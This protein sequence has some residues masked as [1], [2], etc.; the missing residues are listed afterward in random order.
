MPIPQNQTYPNPQQLR[1]ILATATRADRPDRRD[2]TA[3]FDRIRETNP[4]VRGHILTRQTAVS[5]FGWAISPDDTANPGAVAQ[6]QEAETRLSQA[7]QTILDTHHIAPLYGCAAYAVE[8]AVSET[9]Q[10][11]NIRTLPRN[12]YDYVDGL[13]RE[14]INP[15]QSA[16]TRQVQH[17]EA[18][19]LRGYDDYPV[20]Q[21]VLI[22]ELLRFDALKE[23]GN[24]LKKLK[25]I[26]QIVDKGGTAEDRAS[27][28]T[29]AETAIKD[30]FLITSE[31]IE[32]KLNQVASGSAEAFK[33]AIDSLN[34]DISIA[35]LGQAN[36]SELPSGG[37]SRAALQVQKLIS[38]DIHYSD[39][40]Q[41][42][43]FINSQILLH[44]YRLNHDLSSGSAPYRFSI[45]LSEEQDAEKNAIAVR[46]AMSTGLP[47]LRSEIYSRLGFSAPAPDENAD[48]IVQ[49]TI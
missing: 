42:E 35:I 14:Y 49:Q 31:Y 18:L 15:Q 8:W 26:L 24:F 27:A 2:L 34:A 13:F 40:V 44:D 1:Q 23:Q 21:S 32:F 9:G 37:G 19:L 38:A 10:T 33:T 7:V 17:S 30:N 5:S 36:T 25:G 4:R 45:S 28:H 16:E 43:R 29:A 39:I 6:A 47:F 3:I 22:A 41:V 20:L 46:E 48:N 11:A 12:K